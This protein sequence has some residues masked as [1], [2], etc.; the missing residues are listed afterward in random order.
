MPPRTVLLLTIG[1]GPLPDTT[2]IVPVDTTPTVDGHAAEP[3][4]P[5]TSMVT[6]AAFDSVQVAWLANGVAGSTY[7]V[8]TA[9]D[10]AGTPGTYAAF[11]STP[12]SASSAIVSGTPWRLASRAPSA[13]TTSGTWM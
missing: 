4:A 7:V 10:T 5:P 9:T 11:A 3:L 6:A 12:T 8:E 13:S 1:A 2:P